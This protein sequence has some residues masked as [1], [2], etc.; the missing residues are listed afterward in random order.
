MAWTWSHTAE[1]YGHARANLEALPAE[2]LEAIAAEWSETYRCPPGDGSEDPCGFADRSATEA[3]RHARETGHRPLSPSHAPPV[4]A[5]PETLWDLMAAQAT[6]DNGGWDAWACPTGC[7]TVPF[8]PPEETGPG[9]PYAR[10]GR[11]G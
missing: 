9:T 4:S 8:S 11:H 2:T 1:A 6:S 5:D 7:H 10:H 3:D